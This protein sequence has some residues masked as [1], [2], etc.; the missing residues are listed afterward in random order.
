MF[1]AA[2]LMAK[3]QQKMK[4]KNEKLKTWK[5]NGFGEFQ[6]PE[7]RGVG[8]INQII[9]LLYLNGFDCVIKEI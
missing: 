6:S 7:M 9:K 8:R 3:F 1:F 4:L 2:F 5:W